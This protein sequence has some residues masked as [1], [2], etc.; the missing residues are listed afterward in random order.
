MADY[1]KI[2]DDKIE[3]SY[4]RKRTIDIIAYKDELVEIRDRLKEVPKPKTVPDQE[5]LKF[6]NEFNAPFWESEELKK[7]AIYILGIFKD[8][9]QAGQLPEKWITPLLDFQNWL[10]TL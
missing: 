6:W 1:I 9:Y 4:I 8:V 10:K 5:T 2:T 3:K 7:R